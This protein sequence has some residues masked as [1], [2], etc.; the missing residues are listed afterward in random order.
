[1]EQ[2]DMPHMQ[3]KY[4]NRRNTNTFR[5]T[6]LFDATFQCTWCGQ[7][8]F[9]SPAQRDEHAK[10]CEKVGFTNTPRPI[11]LKPDPKQ[12]P[13]P[14]PDHIIVRKPKNKRINM[15]AYYCG[16]KAGWSTNLQKAKK[17]SKAGAILVIGKEGLKDP[18]SEL[19]VIPHPGRVTIAG[20]PGSM[21]FP[22]EWEQETGSKRRE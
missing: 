4:P 19:A 13:D 22:A 15:V 17:Y 11:H 12:D 21:V 8:G 5:G 14:E 18:T 9:K 1:M 3:S 20:Q 6:K 2:T 7:T 10:I 16:K